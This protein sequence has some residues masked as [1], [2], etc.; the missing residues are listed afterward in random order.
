MSVCVCVCVCV[1]AL[2]NGSSCIRCHCLISDWFPCYKFMNHIYQ[3]WHHLFYNELRVATEE[4]SVIMIVK[5]L[6]PRA[7]FEK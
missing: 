4:H 2:N 5:P 7:D 3:V 1:C 6:A